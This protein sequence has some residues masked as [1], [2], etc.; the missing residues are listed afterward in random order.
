MSEPS[1]R[2]LLASL[3][4]LALGGCVA[5]RPE[6]TATQSS[7]PST[8]SSTPTSTATPVA[9]A[10]FGTTW[11]APAHDAGLSNGT[12]AAGPTDPVAELWTV[13]L[14]A[15]TAPVFADATV[16]ASADGAVHA[17]DARTGD[18]RWQ[19]PVGAGAGS[20]WCRTDQVVV[21]VDGAVVALDTAGT[22]QWR[23]E[24][25]D[26]AAL[27]VTTAGIY[28]LAD[29]DPPTV[30]ALSPDGRE[31]WRTDLGEP[32]RP[33]LFAGSGRVFVSSGT[34][35][36]RF[37]QL[38]AATGE[39]LGEPPRSG[40][41]FPAEQFARDGTVYAADAF[42]GNVR[43]TPVDD[44]DG[45][46][47]AT[48]PGGEAGGGLLAGDGSRVYY[49]ANADDEPSVFALGADGTVG[50][51]A[52]FD[53]IVTGRPVAARETVLVP[54]DAGL[55][56]LDRADGTPLWTHAGVG[57]RVAVVDDIVYA[58]GDGSVTAYRP[59]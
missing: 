31:Q 18:R 26:R 20:P 9:P 42:F 1:R 14:P 23:V 43:A 5:D 40:A 44:G 28:W 39:R 36:S 37:W 17:L 13:S 21:P 15:P 24:T 34:H 41:D 53:A 6:T 16:Y 48:A 47:Q 45:W 8:E 55:R 7:P 33:P 58:A 57:E 50:W 27:L 19:T 22:E 56:A 30:V 29:G 59:P 2:G 54:T 3:G 12:T 4:A 49:T 46:S 52:A 35:D 25:P 38:D 10:E 51:T 32:W 11:P